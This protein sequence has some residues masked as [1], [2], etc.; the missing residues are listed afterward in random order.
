[1]PVSGVLSPSFG[2]LV[3]Q[4]GQLNYGSSLESWFVSGGY[5]WTH[6][7]SNGSPVS[8]HTYLMRYQYSQVDGIFPL[9]TG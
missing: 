4:S 9:S 8:V 2:R 1:M 6:R 5:L 3:S 7:N